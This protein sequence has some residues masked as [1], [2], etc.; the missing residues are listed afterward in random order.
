MVLVAIPIN[1]GWSLAGDVA[2]DGMRSFGSQIDLLSIPIVRTEVGPP[3]RWRSA[4]L[5]RLLVIVLG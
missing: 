2:V 3:D 5:V 4:P 1:R